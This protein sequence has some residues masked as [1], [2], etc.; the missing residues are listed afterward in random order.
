MGSEEEDHKG[1]VPFSSHHGKATCCHCVLLLMTLN[2]ITWLR[3]PVVN[4]LYSPFSC[5]TIWQSNPH[6]R[7]KE[8]NINYLEFYTEQFFLSPIYLSIQS[9]INIRMDSWIFGALDYNPVVYYL[10][11]AQISPLDIG[12]FLVS[13]GLL[14]PFD[15]APSFC[16]SLCF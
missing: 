13:K 7:D 8:L 2:L 6:S 5:C 12:T 14:C 16:F 15:V 4:L 11:I 10:F 1:E 3:S 9:L